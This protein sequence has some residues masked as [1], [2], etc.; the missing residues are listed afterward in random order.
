[1]SLLSGLEKYG[2]STS[3]IDNLFEDE[4]KA[5]KKTEKTPKEVVIPKEDDFLLVKS[6]R[7]PICDHVFKM[8]MVK[9]GRAKR[10]EP[11]RDLRPRYE[12]IDVLKYDVAS[13]PYCGYTALNRYFSHVSSAQIKLIRE[14]VMSK[15]RREGF[16][17]EEVD[18][19]PY[20]YEEAIE[21]YK[22]AIFN[23]IV[24]KGKSSEKAYECL[25][26]AWL[27]RGQIEVLEREMPEAVHTI[28]ATKKEELAFYKQA[29]DGFK[30]AIGSELFPMCGMDQGTMD[31]LLAA[32]A[33]RME[34]Y[35]EAARFLASTIGSRT[36]NPNM[37]RRAVDMKQELL[38]TMKKNANQ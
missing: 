11:D 23:T 21:R 16:V 5:R 29:Y 27:Y 9:S 8:K 17:V 25:K 6:T 13:C 1:M 14:G 31:L 18:N 20:S 24:K 4:E 38:E 22:L 34:N 10:L 2:F 37:K 36:V 15:F 12:Y 30:K 26:I 32:M 33:M 3:E 28:D 19:S 35:D 7:C